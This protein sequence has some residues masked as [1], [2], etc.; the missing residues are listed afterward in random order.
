MILDCPIRWNSTYDMLVV[1]LQFKN[2][3]A[4]FQE[5]EQGH[6]NC[7]TEE[8][9]ER[10][11][12][13][14][15][16]LEVFSEAMNMISGSEYLTANKYL[17]VG[18]VR[19]VLDSRCDDQDVFV[20]RMIRKMKEKF[21]KYLKE[22]NLSMAIAAVLDPRCKMVMVNFVFGTIYTKED[23]EI[24][25][26]KVKKALSE[27]FNE[28]K[29]MNDLSYES[30]ALGS[31]GFASSLGDL[32]CSSSLMNVG[33]SRFD[34]FV[35]SVETFQHEKSELE[36]Y[37]EEGLY[38]MRYG[39][40]SSS[41]ACLEWWKSNKLK[42]KILSKMG[43]DI[44]AISASTVASESTF[45]TGSRVID[46]YLASLAKETV[47]ALIC[48]GDWVRKLHGVKKTAKVDEEPIEIQLEQE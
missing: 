38:R 9:W 48:G 10:V 19:E 44:L 8:E 17:V 2:A 12:Q 26:L 15:K 14:V 27:I 20:W 18:R 28:Y 7:P 6:V 47:Q 22:S 21:D 35:Q 39:D 25:V 46:H 32:V 40:S 16:I 36:I 37:L 1:A 41:F 3:L 33:W 43:C 23:A 42:Y 5:F 4:V 13:V 30:S 31:Y 11:E 29:E 24:Q 34:Q 45:S